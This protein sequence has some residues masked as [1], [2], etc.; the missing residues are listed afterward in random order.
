[1]ANLTIRD[2][3]GRTKEALRVQAAK[4]GVSLEAH[5]RHI[6][7]KASSLSSFPS[8][9]ILALAEGYFGQKH[10]I[11]VTLPTRGSRRK[12]VEFRS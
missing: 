4:S 1:M 11:D 3:P 2:L 6:L 10:G 5:A 8:V 12:L 7:Q 9:N